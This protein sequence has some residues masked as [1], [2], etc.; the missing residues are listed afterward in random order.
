MANERHYQ[1]G[2]I[3]PMELV[4]GPDSTSGGAPVQFQV[5]HRYRNTGGPVKVSPD[6]LDR[7]EGPQAPS[8]EVNGQWHFEGGTSLLTPNDSLGE[9]PAQLGTMEG[10]CRAR[11]NWSE[12]TATGSPDELFP[13]MDW[14]NST[15]AGYAAQLP[16]QAGPL[17]DEAFQAAMALSED[18]MDHW[19][20]V[21]LAADDPQ[22]RANED[23]RESPTHHGFPAEHFPTTAY[24]SLEEPPAQ[25]GN[26][27]AWGVPDLPGDELV[28]AAAI[29]AFR[30]PQ[31]QPRPVEA[32][33]W[34]DLPAEQTVNN[35]GAVMAYHIDG[36][37]HAKA[38]F[39]LENP[40]ARLNSE[41]VPEGK[42]V[43]AAF[44]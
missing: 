31:T 34:S 41:H 39:V 16:A 28:V 23:L 43:H 22:R 17:L 12:R 26:M 21:I 29:E 40:E 8:V 11:A 6:A 44:K 3:D 33:W 4:R 18:N 2:F 36:D 24:D 37:Y 30:E 14:S 10:E 5:P 42:G 27:A 1:P 9:P 20:A 15:A 7:P 32:E 13:Y 38:V 25:P 19:W 35:L